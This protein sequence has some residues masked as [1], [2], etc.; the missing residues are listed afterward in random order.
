MKKR[1]TPGKHRSG[2]RPQ[3]QEVAGDG[4]GRRTPLLLAGVVVCAAVLA[5]VVYLMLPKTPDHQD[6]QGNAGVRESGSSDSRETIDLRLREETYEVAR[7]LMADFPGSAYP[8]GLMGT[9]Q[10]AFGN[11]A[12]AEK[13]WRMCLERDPRRSDVYEVLAVAFL[14]KG[15]YEKVAELLRKAQEIDPNLPQVHRRY[16]EALLEM[17]K[18]DEA[19]AAL[20]EEMRISPGSSETH[21][22]LGATYLQQKEYEKAK[23]AYARAFELRPYDPR[24]CYG[25]ATAYRRMGQTDKAT[26]YMKKFTALRARADK[27]ATTQ[28]RSTSK[29]RPAAGILAEALVDA[30]RMYNGQ[31]QL[32]KAEACWLRAATVDPTNTDC[33]RELVKTY[34]RTGRKREALEVCEQLRNL[35][36]MNATYHQITGTVL[37]ELQQFDAAEEPL[38][39]AIELAPESAEAYRSLTGVL[40]I[41]NQKLPEAKVLARRLVELAPTAHHYTLLAQACGRTEDR[42]GELAA[43]KKAAELAPDNEQIQATYRR[44]QERQ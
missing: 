12:E 43:I 15:E 33:R 2:S 21:I 23:T 8:I 29:P 42:S 27:A 6:P 34:R 16:A 36:P 19:L 9:V 17:G 26:E 10:N 32:D 20:Q 44:L 35:D 25:L 38:R 5:I 18:L 41:T 14:R 4:H 40:L 39:K 24:S 31:R 30:A 1:N 7:Q 3:P 22:V 11:S 28:R 13:Y 37:T